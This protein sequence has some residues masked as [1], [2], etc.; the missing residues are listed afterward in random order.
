MHTGSEEAHKA[1][2]APPVELWSSERG[3]PSEGPADNPESHGG[4]CSVDNAKATGTEKGGGC[5]DFTAQGVRL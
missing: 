2:T 4:G 1:D 3:D 5:E